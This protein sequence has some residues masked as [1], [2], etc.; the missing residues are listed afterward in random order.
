LPAVRRVL[1]VFNGKFDRKIHDCLPLD[2]FIGLGSCRRPSRKKR[3]RSDTPHEFRPNKKKNNS[4]STTGYR[5]S[6]NLIVRR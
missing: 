6:P 3:E 5:P 1:D 4:Q 2:T